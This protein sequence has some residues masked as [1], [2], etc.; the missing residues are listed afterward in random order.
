MLPSEV[1]HLTGS[2]NHGRPTASGALTTPNVGVLDVK[3][4]ELQ[5]QAS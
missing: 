4:L 3:W 2:A 5:K 1:A